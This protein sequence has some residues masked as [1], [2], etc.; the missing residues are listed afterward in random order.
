MVISAFANAQGVVQVLDYADDGM[1]I[2][3]D[4]I[5]KLLEDTPNKHSHCQTPT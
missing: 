5:A 2:S 4:N 1:P 3:L